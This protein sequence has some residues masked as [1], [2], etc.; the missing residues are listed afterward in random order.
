[1]HVRNIVLIEVRGQL[2][3]IASL[4][5]PL[6]SGSELRSPGLYGQGFYLLNS[7]VG[8]VASFYAI[9]SQL[10]DYRHARRLCLKREELF[11]DYGDF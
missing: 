3:R 10:R 4:F 9:D 11:K 1:M 6:P 2:C 5:L 8:H 7:L